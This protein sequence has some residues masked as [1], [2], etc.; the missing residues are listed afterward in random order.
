MEFTKG[1]VITADKEAL[2]NTVNCVGIMGKGIALQ[3]KQAYPDNTREY[4][5]AC[6]KGEVRPGRLFIY[7]TGRL[8][9]PKYIIN[10]PTKSHWKARSK[11]QDIELGLDALKKEIIERNIKSIAIPPLGC[12][13]GGLDWQ[14][15]KPLIKKSLSD[16]NDVHIQIFEPEGSPEAAN[17]PV[18]TKEPKMTRARALLIKLMELYSIPEYKLS[19]LEV[20]KLAYFLQVSGENLKLDFKKEKYGPYAENLNFVLQ[21]IEGHFIRGYGD[22]NSRAM[23]NVMDKA[24]EK[25]DSY[26]GSDPEA[27]S[28]LEHVARLIHGFETPYGMELLASVHW[29][30]VN[31]NA[32]TKDEAI[33]KVCAWNTRKK[34]TFRIEHIQKAWDRLVEKQWIVPATVAVTT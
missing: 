2:V 28:R 31:E 16:L 8:G 6:K 4:E 33:E 5:K 1:N 17:M 34:E 22:R 11:I 25:A 15:V 23:I 12:G 30:A 21:L 29:V 9:N 3:F 32:S 27:R 10:F 7:R 14:D 13:N 20:Q 19:L 18:N 26:I 24:S